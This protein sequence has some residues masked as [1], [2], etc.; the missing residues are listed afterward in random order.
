MKKLSV[1]LL[2]AIIL[3]TLISCKSYPESKKA[4]EELEE[5]YGALSE[6]SVEIEEAAKKLG[7]STKKYTPASERDKG[8]AF[9]IADDTVVYR[10]SRTDT[11][12]ENDTEFK[13]EIITLYIG[14]VKSRSS[15][16]VTVTIA[17][18]NVKMNVLSEDVAGA[19]E[20][21]LSSTN[22][23]PISSSAKS[24]MK[25]LIDGKQVS[26][27]AASSDWEV[28]CDLDREVSFIC[29]EDGTFKLKKD[30]VVG[31]LYRET[32]EDSEGRPLK[33]VAYYYDE[34]SN[35]YVEDMYEYVYGKDNSVV[36]TYTYY[37]PYSTQIKEIN[38]S[39]S[40]PADVE[41]EMVVVSGKMISSKEYYESGALKK[42]SYGNAVDSD[43]GYVAKTYS[44][45]GH[46]LSHYEQKPDGT[47]FSIQESYYD[48]GNKKSSVKMVSDAT[49]MR[50][51][52]EYEYY[53]NGKPKLLKEYY[54]SGML[55]S[56]YE[57]Y[58][59]GAVYELIDYYDGEDNHVKQAIYD[60]RQKNTY[61]PNGQEHTITVYFDFEMTRV[62]T[63]TEWQ[64]S[65]QMLYDIEYFNTESSLVRIY[66]EWYANGQLKEHYENNENGEKTEVYQY[67]E[68]GDV[69]YHYYVSDD[70]TINKA[71]RFDGGVRYYTWF[72]NGDE[73]IDE[74]YDNGNQYY[75]YYTAEYNK[76][77]EI[78]YQPDP[79]DPTAPPIETESRYTYGDGSY[80]IWK[81]YPNGKHKYEYYKD[82][83]GN[84]TETYY[85]ELG[86]PMN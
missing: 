16:E 25:E 84:V 37:Y 75:Y 42:E 27:A 62:H 64:E 81:Y 50:Y 78:F 26:V 44:E 72:S 1:I 46:L 3:L 77:S 15:N 69:Q 47:N 83:D 70:G 21:M 82:A 8:K 45:S 63:Y 59:T 17:A 33:V 79:N 51:E 2:L 5:K 57:Y 11:E 80:R 65:G 43:E 34:E 28:I 13:F 85:N 41:G 10:T 30:I 86:Y 53:E 67:F 66:K 36:I 23:A 20:A 60:G 6:L 56:R 58:E 76:K 48:N 35:E 52:W 7:G 74:E 40:L 14:K 61:Y 12:R 22:S 29:S 49:Y 55:K 19:K 68:N 18:A 31:R 38:V 32:T 39:E 54:E 4:F 73:R 24:L 9:A 71:E